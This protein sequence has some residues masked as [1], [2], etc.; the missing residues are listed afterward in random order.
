M[1][2]LGKSYHRH[3]FEV[4]AVDQSELALEILRSIVEQEDLDLP[5]GT[6]DIN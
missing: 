2:F 3:Y 1:F 5:V 6:Y 4:T